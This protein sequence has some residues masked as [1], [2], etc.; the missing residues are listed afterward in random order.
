MT[1]INI[2]LE[3]MPVLEGVKRVLVTGG[4]GQIAY[5]LVPHLISGK[6]FGPTTR[7]IIH[8][9]DIPGTENVLRGVQ[10]EIEDAASPVVVG[11]VGT[12]DLR[13]ACTGVD[14]AILL[15]GF[16]R[17]PGMERKDLLAKNVEIISAHAGALQDHASP[18]VKVLVVANPANTLALVA[19]KR[20][21]A[22]PARNFS[23]LTRLDHDRLRGAVAKKLT[24]LRGPGGEVT[25][26]QVRNAVIWG[27]H[28]STQVPSAA[29]AEV[30]FSPDRHRA[31]WQP[32][33]DV[34]YDETWVHE[35][36]VTEVQ[37]RGA[38]VLAARK[39]SSALSAAQAIANH[40]HDWVHGTPE[41]E[42]V[43]MGVYTEPGNPYDV[44]ADIFFSFPV[45]CAGGGWRVVPGMTMSAETRRRLPATID[46]L[47]EERGLALS[48]LGAGPA[49]VAGAA[50]HL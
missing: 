47:V 44:P 46:E 49:A 8:L 3:E 26:A 38:A 6:V 21:A 35:E 16:P 39:L 15:G 12:T 13:T 25:A 42:F 14:Y 27:N 34:L 24:S 11:V 9:L 41:G 22:L 17:L 48:L 50:A 43:S 30:N 40:F 36:L 1:S 32:I 7:L 18:D 5:A 4:A 37:Q 2:P 33:R 10:M 28:S 23:C 45:T 19:R 29:Q 20:A 31:K